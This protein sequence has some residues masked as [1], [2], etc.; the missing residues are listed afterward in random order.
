MALPFQSG[1]DSRQPD[2]RVAPRLVVAV[3]VVLLEHF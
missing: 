2:T 1:I 3:A